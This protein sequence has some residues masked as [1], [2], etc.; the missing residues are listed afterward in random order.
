MRDAPHGLILLT[1]AKGVD[2]GE[3]FGTSGGAFVP[4]RCLAPQKRAER[5]QQPG[6]VVRGRSD[7]DVEAAGKPRCAVKRECLRTDDDELNAMGSQGRDAL[8]EVWR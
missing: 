7:Q 5:G 8:V 1:R 4:E 3:V 6:G 2:V